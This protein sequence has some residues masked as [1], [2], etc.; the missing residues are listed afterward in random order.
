MDWRET[1]EAELMKLGGIRS[2]AG[3]GAGWEEVRGR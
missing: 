1:Q 2:G 3:W